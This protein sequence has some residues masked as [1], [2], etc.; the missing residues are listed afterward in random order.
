MMFRKISHFFLIGILIFNSFGNAFPLLAHFESPP[1]DIEEEKSDLPSENFDLP[2]GNFDSP[3]ED[4][5]SPERIELFTDITTFATEPIYVFVSKTAKCNVAEDRPFADACEAININEPNSTQLQKMCGVATATTNNIINYLQTNS[6]ATIAD[7]INVN[8]IG[9]AT[10]QNIT[11]INTQCK[12]KQDAE[13]NS[14]AKLI[15]SEVYYDDY[16]DDE[17]EEYYRDEEWIE[18]FNIGEGDFNG[19][20][21]LSGKIFKD[22][23]SFTYSNISIP[24]KGFI[25]LANTGYFFQLP[26]T[27]RGLLINQKNNFPN[28]DIPDTEELNIELLIDG[29]VIDVFSAEA[30]RVQQRDDRMVAFQKIILPD[31]TI[32]TNS[33]EYSINIKKGYKGN[34]GALL[35][36]TDKGYVDYTIPKPEKPIDP[37]PLDA[38]SKAAEDILILTETFRGNNTYDPYLEFLIREDIQWGY[39]KLLLSGSLLQTSLLL[40]LSGETESYDRDRLEKNTRLIVTKKVGNLAEA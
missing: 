22:Q 7:L 8:N 27:S 28:F 35:I 9:V 16:E 4:L 17:R 14:L 1:I 25:V 18:I 24:A 13:K 32:V 34:P 12:T 3:A 23:T 39:E 37:P 36:T 15:I 21:T 19:S 33:R 26:N 11:N 5:D 6:F 2:S 40:D 38:C 20:F 10:L 31:K 30:S 29:T